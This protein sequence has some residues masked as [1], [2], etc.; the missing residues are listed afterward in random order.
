MLDKLASFRG[1]VENEIKSCLIGGGSPVF[2]LEAMNAYHMGFGDNRGNP[3]SSSKGKYMRS[4]FCMAICA[5]LGGDPDKAVPAAASLELAH[6]TSLIF[7]DIQDAGKE[8][9][10]QPTMWTVWG[11]DQAI[12]AGLALSCHARLAVHRGIERGIPPETALRILY[13]LENA[14]LDLCQGQ[15]LDISFQE[16]VSVGREDYFRMVRGKTGALFGAACEV[17]AICAGA[18]DKRAAL[19]REFG[20]SMGI[21]FQIHDDYLGIWGDEGTVGKTANDLTEKKRS[22]PV[23]LALE[24]YPAKMGGWLNLPTL[25]VGMDKRIKFW[26]EKVGIKV[27]TRDMAVEHMITAREKLKELGLDE[28]WYNELARNLTFVVERA[29]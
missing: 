25:P 10:G 8:R 29:K 15:F 3:I 11:I 27:K 5:G 20:I 6:R 1:K 28:K 4:I 16:T 19:A 17:G 12:N 18:G 24:K 2:G 14:V 23:V 21:A 22:L 26:M 13:V 9:N 7:D